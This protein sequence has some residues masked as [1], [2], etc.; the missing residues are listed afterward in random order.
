M[1]SKNPKNLPPKKGLLNQVIGTPVWA[2]DATNLKLIKGSPFASK[3]KAAKA[4][5]VPR[6][7]LDFVLNKGRTAGSK[8]IYVY[9]RALSVK[10][11]KPLI[12]KVESIQLGLK[13][14]VYVY[15]ANTLELINNAPFDSLLDTANFYGVDYRTIARHLNTNKAVKRGDSLVYFFKQK[16]DTQ[17][18]KQLLTARV[19]GD[20]RN[21]NRKVWVYIAG[22]LPARGSL[23]LINNCPFDSIFSAVSYIGIDKSTV[24]KNLDTGKPVTL[25]KVKLTVY[26]LTKEISSELKEKFSKG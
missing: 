17:F 15:D 9:S 5:G 25:R 20:S 12:A 23:E 2:Y 14:P 4:L 16:L 7:T 1:C 24:Y 26:F 8:A 22:S 13:V 10:E 11:I 19:I 18:S 21:Y 6:A 3:N